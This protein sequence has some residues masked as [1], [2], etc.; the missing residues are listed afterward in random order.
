VNYKAI[1][2]AWAYGL[3]LITLIGCENDQPSTSKTNGPPVAAATPATE[4]KV[5]VI[6]MFELGEDQGDAAGEFQLWKARQKLNKRFAFPQSHH[7]LFLNEETGVLGMVTGM[8]TNRSSSAIMALGLDPRFD[9]RKA[10][11]LVVGIGGFDPDDASIGSG[12]WSEWIVDGDFGHEIDAR[13]I[14]ED[15]ETGFFPLFTKEPYPEVMPPN[16]GEVFQLNGK[17]REWAYQ[18]TKDTPLSDDEHIAEQRKLYTKHPNAQRL[19]FVLKGDSISS[20][21][22]W[23]GDLMTNWANKWVK[24]WSKGQGEF[25]SAGMEDTGTAQSLFYL[26][27]A[28]KADYDRLMV[29]RTA[30]NF[31]QPPPGMT[32]AENLAAEGEDYAGLGLALESGYRLG[33]RVV[34]TLVDG[35]GKY[36][37]NLPYEP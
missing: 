22:F 4:V 35:W 5:V 19:P 25:V 20:M 7:D 24:Y 33:S 9:L 37:N 28:G 32:A 8:G 36:Q 21:T 27:R 10:Y 13:E 26:D 30:S 6:T 31:T 18:L 17:L 16:Q 12:A 11:W 14:P 34:E 23:H 2:R 15:W 29:L 1:L 3:V